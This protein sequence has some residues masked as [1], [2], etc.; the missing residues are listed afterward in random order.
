MVKL[1]ALFI[2]LP[3]VEL[4]LLIEVGQRI[5]TP[6]TLG[7]ILV[8]GIVGATL[9]RRQGLRVFSAVQEEM[10]DGRMPTSSLLDGLMILIA[11]ALLV[12]PGVLTDAVGF[13]CL[14]PGFRNL[15]KAQLRARFERAVMEQRVHVHFD[16]NPSGGTFRPGAFDATADGPSPPRSARGS[17]EEVIDIESS[18]FR[19][20]S[21]SDPDRES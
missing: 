9:A 19:S 14:H 21:Q 1:L 4:A 8:T 13:L 6:A 7:L 16:E 2:L 18:N 10:A 12:T 11:S 3:A 5:G 17:S 15:V 20:A